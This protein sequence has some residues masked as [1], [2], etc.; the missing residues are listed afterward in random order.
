MPRKPTG[1]PP[2][3]PPKPTEEHLREG[4]YRPARHRDRA[5][6]KLSKGAP[7][8][9]SDPAVEAVVGLLSEPPPWWLPCDLLLAS[10]LRESLE[11]RVG[12]RAE[13]EAGN[14]SA[15]RELR[16]LD[17]EVSRMLDALGLTPASRQRMGVEAPP[18]VASRLEDLRSRARARSMSVLGSSKAAD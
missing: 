1:N 12:L 6:V 4:T 11:E 3:R 7:R 16:A 14:I 17:A 5:P 18:A 9:H 10:I 15:S 8:H 13:V 2:G